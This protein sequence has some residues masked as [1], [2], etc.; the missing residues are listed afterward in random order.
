MVWADTRQWA[1]TEVAGVY[2]REGKYRVMQ[3]RNYVG[4]FDNRSDA[5]AALAESGAKPAIDR[6]RREPIEQFSRKFASYLDW[7]ADVGFE[8]ADLAAG[9]KFRVTCPQLVRAAPATYQLAAEGKEEP[10]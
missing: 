8:P 5:V 9:K 6:S 7:A 3:G 4:L 2:E 10:W 1:P